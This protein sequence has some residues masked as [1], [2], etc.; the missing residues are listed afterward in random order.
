MGTGGD[1]NRRRD[2]DMHRM[3]R[4]L[5]GAVLAVGLGLTGCS[6]AETADTDQAPTQSEEVGSPDRVDGGDEDPD[7]VDPGTG[8]IDDDDNTVGDPPGDEGDG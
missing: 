5:C 8:G 1:E 3:G 4:V 6:N 7:G 2:E